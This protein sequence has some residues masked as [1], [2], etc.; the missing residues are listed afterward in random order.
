MC[1]VAGFLM[2]SKSSSSVNF[3]LITKKMT[4]SIKHRGPNDS[5]CWN[6]PSEGIALGHRRLSILDLSDAGHQPMESSNG[7]YVIAFNGEIYNHLQ[8]RSDIEKNNGNISW[9]GH[10]DTETILSAFETFGIQE[11]L[12]KFVGMFAFSLWDK[13]NKILTLARDR[14]GE[15]P[16]YYGWQNIANGRVFLFGS[17]LK[18]LKSFPDIDLRVDRGSLSLFLKHAYVPNPY[19]IYENIFSLEPGQFLQ[20]SLTNKMT[21]TVNYWEASEIIKKGSFE[22]YKG[23]PK[24]AVKDLKNLLRHTIKS[25]MISDV[26]LGAFLSGGIDSSTVVSIMQEQADIPVKTFTIGFNEKGFDEAKY[27]KSIANHLGTD[28]TELYI[29]ANDAI[30][31]IPDMHSIYCEPFADSTQIPNFIVSRLANNDVTVALSGDGGDELFGGYSRYN[32]IDNIWKKINYFPLSTR[33][34]ISKIL[35]YPLQEKSIYSRYKSKTLTNLSKRIISGTNL[36]NSETI[37]KLY[38]HVIT[39]I[40]FPEDVVHDGYLKETKLDDLKPSFGDISN[41]E[42]MMATD[43][44]NYLPDDILTKVDRAAMRTSLETRV[45]FLDHNIVEF[46]WRLPI[47][48]KVKE[49]ESKW[50]LHQI[51]KDFLPESLTKREKMGFSV[52]IHEW[53]RGPLKEW[54]EEL[55]NKDRLKS[56]GFF[57]EEIVCNKWNEHL[58]GKVNNITFLWPILMFQSWL[59]NQ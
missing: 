40:P 19:S 28:H 38:L 45:P 16:M 47:S 39:Q 4:D 41:I 5:G 29:S 27:A 36:I 33:N 11:S 46:A 6:N 55:L 58:Y 20:V 57:D 52:P 56:E 12:E 25:Q 26:P 53:I 14:L 2:D 44:I 35:T 7:R 8:I 54:C 9:R 17:E 10:S 34:L 21:K 49:G 32:H 59:E 43:T 51:L 23:T 24:E 22:E 31:V 30:K 42:K 37:D 1:G 3:D 48:Y 15:K 18:A 13:K 50:P